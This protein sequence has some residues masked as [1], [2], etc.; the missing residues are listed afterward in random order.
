[1][2][3]ELHCVSRAAYQ[4]KEKSLEVAVHIKRNPQLL[5]IPEGGTSQFGREGM[6]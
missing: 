6:S 3:M 2:G 4:L 5:L 1:M